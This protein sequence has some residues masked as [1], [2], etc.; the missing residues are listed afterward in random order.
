M[1]AVEATDKD[2]TGSLSFSR[3]AEHEL[4]EESITVYH[5]VDANALRACP[6]VMKRG[7]SG[8]RLRTFFLERPYEPKEI[9][10]EGIVYARKNL[11]KHFQENDR[12]L[13]IR[14]DD[15]KACA[16]AGR[17]TATFEDPQGSK[18]TLDLYGGF[19]RVL[20]EQDFIAA[21]EAIR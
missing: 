11:P 3:A 1:G 5:S 20:F 14:L 13:W 6:A 21:L 9:F 15:L 17:A 10:E 8:V 4:Y 19:Q 18:H 2:S 16:R 12:F 7:A